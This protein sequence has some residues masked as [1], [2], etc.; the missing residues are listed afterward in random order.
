MLGALP[1]RQTDKQATSLSKLSREGKFRNDDLGGCAPCRIR[2]D[3]MVRYDGQPFAVPANIMLLLLR[4]GAPNTEILTAKSL[5][6]CEAIAAKHGISLPTAAS[7]SAPASAAVEPH[8]A[9]EA[10]VGYDVRRFTAP[11]RAFECSTQSSAALERARA[12]RE[13]RSHRGMPTG[14]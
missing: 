13:Q 6:D 7:S 2:R 5:E 9:S 1:D 3:T 4:N 8:A 12:R 10:V 11:P 14:E